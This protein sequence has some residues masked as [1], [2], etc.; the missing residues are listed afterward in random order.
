MSSVVTRED[1]EV[2]LTCCFRHRLDDRSVVIGAENVL[3]KP[4]EY[5]IWCWVF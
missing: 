3:E 5:S 1:T 4:L 2:L